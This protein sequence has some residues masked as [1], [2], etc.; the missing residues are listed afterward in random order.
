[1]NARSTSFHPKQLI[2]LIFFGPTVGLTDY[3]SDGRNGVVGIVL[4]NFPGRKQSPK[5]TPL[6]KANASDVVAGNPQGCLCRCF[7]TCLFFVRKKLS[8]SLP[9]LLTL[10]SGI[11]LKFCHH[12]LFWIGG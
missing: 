4:L 9:K 10:L 11:S 3:A 2:L 1:M 5:L 7:S 6:L 8:P 12:C